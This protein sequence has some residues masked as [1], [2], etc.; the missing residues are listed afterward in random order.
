MIFGEIVRRHPIRRA[1]FRLAVLLSNGTRSKGFSAPLGFALGN[2]TAILQQ[3]WASWCMPNK[4]PC[5]TLNKI[6]R[7]DNKFLE[8][9]LTNR[10]P[11]IE[12]NVCFC[13]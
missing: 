9:R 4:T 10:S 2:S 7:E 3:R 5:F 13:R 12:K 11:R 8:T 1:G 6:L